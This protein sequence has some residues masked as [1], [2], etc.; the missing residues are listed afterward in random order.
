MGLMRAS[1]ATVSLVLGLAS[2]ILVPACG[3]SSSPL[4]PPGGGPGPGT[5]SG[6]GSS[7]GSGPCNPACAPRCD[8]LAEPLCFDCGGDLIPAECHG[9]SWVCPPVCLCGPAL[10]QQ[11]A[12]GNGSQ[13]GSAITSSFGLGVI[14][15]GSFGGTIGL[16]GETFTSSEPDID[17]HNAVAA[18]LFPDGTHEW[19]FAFGDLGDEFVSDAFVD[20]DG[21]TTVLV[22]TYRSAQSVGGFV[23]PEAS[24]GGLFVIKLG[25]SGDVLFASGFVGG[26][27]GTRAR[28]ASMPNSDIMLAGDT[29]GT[30]DFGGGP[31]TGDSTSDVVVARLDPSGGLVY[32]RRF[33]GTSNE[34]ATDIAIAPNGDAIVVGLFRETLDFGLGPLTSAGEL[35][36]F[37]IRLDDLGNVVQSTAYG[38]AGAEGVPSVVV[39]SAGNIILTA[40]Y[41]D[42]ADFGGGSLATDSLGGV[43][44]SYDPGGTLRWA[45]PFTGSSTAV[46][47]GDIF[48]LAVDS[49]DNVVLAGQFQGTFNIG[50]KTHDSAG[51]YDIVVAR[52]GPQGNVLDSCRYGSANSEHVGDVATDPVVGEVLLT[53]SYF[54]TLDFG[55]GPMIGDG[56]GEMF[57]VRLQHTD[58]Q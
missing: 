58:V 36:V 28:A 30:I 32:A 21:A 10:W 57:Y 51:D 2:A 18:R 53:G 35:D 19:S 27:N 33:S 7:T 44:A 20:A 23:L 40:S 38:G 41:S 24:S 4:P 55:L 54:E 31:I 16:G 43:V 22:G 42:G 8:E 9:A 50:H 13:T 29:S 11:T 1:L 52:I 39:D 46:S 6:T 49:A 25:L 5:G 12:S 37:M 34:L 56:N 17:Q 26:A 15:A 3:N 48:R 47:G 45:H 14:V